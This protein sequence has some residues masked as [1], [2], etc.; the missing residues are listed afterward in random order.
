[1]E[2]RQRAHGPLAP[3]RIV[4]DLAEKFE[5]SCRELTA[6]VS[7]VESAGPEV[8]ED[9][10]R[11]HLADTQQI[12][13][14]LSDAAS[15]LDRAEARDLTPADRQA[16]D[17]RR[18]RARSL[19]AEAVKAYSRLSGTVSDM[20]A[21]IAAE[22][23][24]LGTGRRAFRHYAAAGLADAARQALEPLSARCVVC[25]LPPVEERVTA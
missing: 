21:E 19:L 25:G 16:V 5:T 1:M 17:M 3:G 2:S 4:L 12:R 14:R 13:A 15:A 9:A 22:R 7:Q 8:F 10:C 6:S 24:S 11:R 20:M 23:R 18:E